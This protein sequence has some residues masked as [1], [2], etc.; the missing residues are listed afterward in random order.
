VFVAVEIVQ[1]LHGR[2]GLMARAPWLVALC[3]GL[4]HGFGFA[5]ALAEVGLPERAIPMALLCFNV[6]V[7][8]GQLLFITAVLACIAMLRRVPARLPTWS[9][10][11]PPYAIGG[12]AAFWM[13]QRV[14]MFWH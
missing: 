12:V 7:E 1:G 11:V 2:A 3:F 8:L 5:G 13:C 6:G 10:Y 4:L 14:V 9:P